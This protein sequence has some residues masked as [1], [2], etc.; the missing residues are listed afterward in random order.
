MPASKSRRAR[1]SRPR[2]TA[3]RTARCLTRIPGAISYFV[4]RHTAVGQNS[5]TSG[6]LIKKFVNGALVG[7]KFV[8]AADMR[9]AVKAYAAR[10]RGG[11]AP[12]SPDST[13]TATTPQGTVYTQDNTSLWQ[14]AKQ[15]VVSGTIFAFMYNAVGSLFDNE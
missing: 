2:R 13:G 10:T 5:R 1:A 3:R 14:T 15:S 7:Q 8:A 12:S 9:R 4:E 6:D 11:F